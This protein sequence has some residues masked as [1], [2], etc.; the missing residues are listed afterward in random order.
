MRDADV[1]TVV[2]HRTVADILRAG[3]ER[4]PDRILLVFDDLDGGVQEFTWRQVLERSTSIARALAVTGVSPGDHVHLHLPNRPE[5]IFHWFGCALRGA[6]MVPTN[7]ASSV[8]ELEYILGHVGR[9]AV[10]DR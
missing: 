3:A 5:F 2:G 8:A 4:T 10:G 7:V 9:G 1:L 6:V